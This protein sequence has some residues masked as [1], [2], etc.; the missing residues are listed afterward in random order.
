MKYMVLTA[1]HCDGFCLWDSGASDYNVSHT[2]FGRDVCRELAQ[3]AHRRGMHIG[4]YYSP[5]DW[6]D[7]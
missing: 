7:P 5:M 1:K 6:R 4:W 2:P 3:A